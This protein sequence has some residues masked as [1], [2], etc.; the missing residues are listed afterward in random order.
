MCIRDRVQ[1]G[2]TM[3]LRA[4]ITEHDPKW[5]EN[6]PFGPKQKPNKSYGTSG[7]IRTT[8]EAKNNQKSDFFKKTAPGGW[9]ADL[10]LCPAAD[11][12]TPCQFTFD[13]FFSNSL[14]HHARW[15]CTAILDLGVA[16]VRK[17]TLPLSRYG[18]FVVSGPEHVSETQSI[19]C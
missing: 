11:T 16:S 1:V 8:P 3:S 19:C 4:Q 13:W 2:S 6:R 5:V 15:N 9:L 10:G 18:N 12:L 7:A 17:V 14:Q